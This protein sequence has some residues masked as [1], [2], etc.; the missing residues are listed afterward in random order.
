MVSGVLGSDPVRAARGTGPKVVCNAPAAPTPRLPERKSRLVNDLDMKGSDQF[1]RNS[2]ETRART[3]KSW[4]LPV[5][6]IFQ[7]AW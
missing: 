2:G 6:A 5:A 7:S 3:N 1:M 4:T